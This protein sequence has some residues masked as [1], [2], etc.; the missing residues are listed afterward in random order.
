M[1]SRVFVDNYKCFSNSEILLPAGNVLVSGAN[2]SG[3]TT[4]F[5]VLHILRDIICFGADV[6]SDVHLLGDTYTRWKRQDGMKTQRFELDIDGNGG[7]Y[8][9]ELVVDN[10]GK[11][12]SSRILSESLLYCNKPLFNY[13][14]S[15]VHLYDN[16][17][18]QEKVVFG[19]DWSKSFI[20]SVVDRPEN[21][22]LLW[23]RNWME[24][25]VVVNPD[26]WQIHSA[27]LGESSTISRTMSNF[28]EWFRYLK[29]VAPDNKYSDLLNDLK[30]ALRGF[31]GMRFADLGD[32]AKELRI[33][34]SPN[35]EYS[36]KE[37]SEGQRLM[38]VLYTAF[39]FAMAEGGTFCVD[40]P[41]NF[42]GLN[43]IEPLVA[44]LMDDGDIACQRIVSSHH[45]EFYNRVRPEQGLWF[46]R[47]SGVDDS[48][49]RV[50]SF[51]KVFGGR[52]G[53]SV[54]EV[55]LRGW[56]D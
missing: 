33:Q 17:T 42:L 43:E 36:L 29:Q 16:D 20:S 12:W 34:M 47:D 45:P 49:T 25:T 9:Y 1:I 52:S 10:G 41:D 46:C 40:E 31:N 28:A 4:F 50:K 19:S 44:T 3:K 23:F 55:V 30:F 48:A 27:A 8:R 35:G 51:D 54:S 26:P 21:S 7:R 15:N 5:D 13:E 6:N 24:K 38:I 56:E 22:K 14:H 32:S 39:R 37:L 2:G 11:H 18:Y 53:L